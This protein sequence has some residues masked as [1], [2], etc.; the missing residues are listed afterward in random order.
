MVGYEKLNVK[1]SDSKANKLKSA[2]KNQTGVAFRMNIKIVE[3][4][5]L[6]H[7]L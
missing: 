3:E 5:H 6:P 4:N 7:E 2:V 1:I